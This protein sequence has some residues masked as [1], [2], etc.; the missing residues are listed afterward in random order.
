MIAAWIK[1]RGD[2]NESMKEGSARF[3]NCRRRWFGGG[4]RTMSA[5]RG[6]TVAQ[7]TTV[8]HPESH[9]WSERLGSV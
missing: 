5:K 9:L 7:Q 6:T 2:M 4:R 3:I 8:S 1:F